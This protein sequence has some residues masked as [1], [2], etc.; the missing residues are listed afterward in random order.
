[1][2]VALLGLS[3]PN[4]WLGMLMLL[5]FALYLGWF[6][7]SGSQTLSSLV[8]PAFTLAFGNMAFISRITRSSML[9]PGVQSGGAETRFA[10]CFD[11]HCHRHGP[12]V[13]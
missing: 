3:M 2:V 9:G 7:T 8:L 13:V 4:F 11:P 1:M 5:L 6:P 12:A 10:Q